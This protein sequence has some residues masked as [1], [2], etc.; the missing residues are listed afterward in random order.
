MADVID[1]DE[2]VAMLCK[3]C[4]KKLYEG[5]KAH[6]FS[7]SEEPIVVCEECAGAGGDG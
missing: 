4:G 2:G 3:S 7:G 6:L 5:D 1:T